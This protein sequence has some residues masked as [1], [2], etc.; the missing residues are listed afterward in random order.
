MP[1]PALLEH[2]LNTLGVIV[3]EAN[4][5]KTAFDSGQP[6]LREIRQ[7]KGVQI[8]YSKLL[9]VDPSQYDGQH[10]SH[11]VHAGFRLDELEIHKGEIRQAMQDEA[12]DGIT[13]RITLQDYMI[14]E[15]HQMDDFRT[16]RQST[17]INTGH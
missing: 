10:F 1:K 5:T 15:C 4:L 13:V 11:M 14:K 2:N 9:T 17:R 3:F 8:F 7:S 12:I 16:V 6:R